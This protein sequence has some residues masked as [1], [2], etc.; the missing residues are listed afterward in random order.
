V[1]TPLP[2]P[3]V[4]SDTF[5]SCEQQHVRNDHEQVATTRTNIR[6][7][8]VNESSTLDAFLNDLHVNQPASL[9]PTHLNSL[10]FIDLHS[11]SSETY[12][13]TNSTATTNHRHTENTSRSTGD[14]HRSI[15]NGNCT[16][17]AHRH[18]LPHRSWHRTTA[19]YPTRT[20]SYGQRFLV[21]ERSLPY[22]LQQLPQLRR[23]HQTYHGDIIDDDSSS[24][25]TTTTTN[26][27]L[28]MNH[29]DSS[30]DDDARL[31]YGVRTMIPQANYS[32][33]FQSRFDRQF[34]MYPRYS[35]QIPYLSEFLSIN[36][37]DENDLLDLS[38]STV[39]RHSDNI[40]LNDSIIV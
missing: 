34:V 7:S 39:R 18:S 8:R 10:L 30:V 3:I 21:R 16:N 15:D 26:S 1:S 4:S 9:D 6:T 19:S 28:P 36:R 32:T 40:Q 31:Y 2:L 14:Y 23:Q 13:E 29:D 25:V 12:P 33:M 27:S 37:D 24:S 17:M 5:R 20:L 35:M 11:T 38:S 22:H